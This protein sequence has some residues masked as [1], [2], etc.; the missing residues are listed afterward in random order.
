MR[1][2]A[3]PL[4]ASLDSHGI[5]VDISSPAAGASLPPGETIHELP[6]AVSHFG[7]V[8]GAACPRAGLC[9][10]RTD[11]IMMRPPPAGLTIGPAAWPSAHSQSSPVTGAP[12]PA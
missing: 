6:L 11:G 4:T 8:A 3:Q 9:A 2:T 7:F 5:G 10:H 1:G 12:R